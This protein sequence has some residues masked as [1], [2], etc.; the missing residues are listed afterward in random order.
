VKEGGDPKEGK[1]TNLPG[2]FNLP[3]LNKSITS[4]IQSFTNSI[5]SFCLSF[6]SNDCSLSF[7]FGFFNDK[8]S[9]FS[10]L[11]CDLFLFNC[12]SEFFTESGC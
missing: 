8:F 7:L 6:G 3:K 10:I 9:T 4:P 11:L 1:R 12:G 5:S 2:S